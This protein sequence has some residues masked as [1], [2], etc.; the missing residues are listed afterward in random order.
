MGTRKLDFPYEVS[1]YVPKGIRAI[2]LQDTLGVCF[3]VWLRKIW[4]TRPS[5]L[6][7]PTLIVKILLSYRKV[8]ARCPISRTSL[9]P[10]HRRYE[11]V[12]STKSYTGLQC[13]TGGSSLGVF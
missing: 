4:K 13:A 11:Q 2:S 10:K 8:L 7:Y 12:F 6:D 9:V 1:N 5:P 3:W